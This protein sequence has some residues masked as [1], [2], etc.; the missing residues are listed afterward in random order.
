M[1]PITNAALDAGI[2]PSGIAQTRK[3]TEIDAEDNT[4]MHAQ[5]DLYARLYGM[6]LPHAT[7][8]TGAM[9]FHG[10]LSH[11]LPHEP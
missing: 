6:T 3:D 10:I 5:T 7:A 9:P 1:T 4:Y 2:H 8:R 11:A